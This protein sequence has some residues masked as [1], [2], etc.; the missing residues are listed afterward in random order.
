MARIFGTSYNNGALIPKG[1]VAILCFGALIESMHV[2]GIFH[3][4]HEYLRINSMI[5]VYSLIIQLFAGLATHLVGKD[6]EKLL[7]AHEI[8]RKFY[9]AEE[10]TPEHFTTLDSTIDYAIFSLKCFTPVSFVIYDFIM[11]FNIILPFIDPDTLHGFLLNTTIVTLGSTMVW[12]LLVLRE[13]QTIFY[14]MQYIAMVKVFEMK[15]I[16]LGELLSDHRNENI[17]VQTS[18]EDMEKRKRL[19]RTIEQ[20]LIQLIR[21]YEAFYEFKANILEYMEF[22]NYIALSTGSIAIGLSLLQL[23][24]VSPAIG[25]SLALISF[26][27]VLVPCVVGT[28][29]STQNRKLVNAVCEFPW[30]NLSPKMKKVYLQFI[31]QCDNTNEFNYTIIG[32]VNME[33][34]TDVMKASYS[35]MTYMMNML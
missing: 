1:L 18:V 30:Y 6:N 26:Y 19:L 22:S 28:V 21:E 35:Y 25:M 4:R 34:F 31:H 5:I 9:E 11:S 7:I 8:A 20:Q 16:K 27:Q 3:N 15:L 10:K 29:M 24:L 12:T 13:I 14:P 23:W 33:L 17:P 32:K 2:Y